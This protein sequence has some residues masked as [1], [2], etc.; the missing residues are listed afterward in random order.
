VSEFFALD[1]D[2][3]SLAVVQNEQKDCNIKPIIGSISSLIKGKIKF[4]D[5][6]LV[7]S[8]GLFDYL[9]D[10]I[11]TKLCTI[12]FDMLASGGKMVIGNF[13][14]KSHGR[15]YMASFMDWSLVYR[16]TSDLQR[17]TKKIPLELL[18]SQIAYQ[19]AHCNVAFLELQKK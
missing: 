6:Q 3:E 18:S 7:Y 10:P 1:Q 12:M 13:R 4:S 17:I 9:S 5:L 16:D 2:E 15:G 8:S 19:D 11:A 14:P